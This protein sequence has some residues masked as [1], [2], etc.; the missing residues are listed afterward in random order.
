MIESDLAT[1]VDLIDRGVQ[2]ALKIS[3]EAKSSKL[4][5]F[6]QEITGR[7]DIAELRKDAIAFASKM[8]MPGR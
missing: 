3:K 8:Y 1:I 6:V 7:S 2:V 5:D 4:S